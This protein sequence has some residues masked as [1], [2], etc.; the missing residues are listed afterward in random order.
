[1]NPDMELYG[2]QCQEHIK[3]VKL[4]RNGL[5]SREFTQQL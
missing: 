1:M 3:N 5:E 4:L 2:A